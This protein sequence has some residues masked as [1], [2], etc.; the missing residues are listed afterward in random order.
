M[1]IRLIQPKIILNM[2]RKTSSQRNF[3]VNFGPRHKFLLNWVNSVSKNKCLSLVELPEKIRTGVFALELLERLG[4]PFDKKTSK[5][6]PRS[7]DDCLSNL[8]TFLKALEQKGFCYD[9]D[10]QM[11]LYQGKSQISWEIIEYIFSSIYLPSVFDSSEELFSWY[12]FQTQCEVTYPD[13]LVLFKDGS[14]LLKSLA[15]LFPL[16][17]YHDFPETKEEII[18]NLGLLFK[19]LSALQ[20][21]ALFTSEDFFLNE[22]ADCLYVQLWLVFKHFDLKANKTITKSTETSSKSSNLESSFIDSKSGLDQVEKKIMHEERK[23]MYISD[24][25]SKT[26]SKSLNSVPSVREIPHSYSQPVLSSNEV[27][28]CF[29]LTPRI[30]KAWIEGKMKKVLISFVPNAEKFS[31]KQEFYVMELKDALIM[32]LVFVCEA[33]EIEKFE[34]KDLEIW[35]WVRKKVLRLAFGDREECLKYLTGFELMGKRFGLSCKSIVNI[36]KF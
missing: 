25:R 13:L 31:L 36:R 18:S 10:C 12:S 6:P 14:L 4:I 29:L 19:S 8:R 26:Q 20:I 5:L 23:L 30:V 34:L 1:K 32:S 28:I 27:I 33:E 2:I 11:C 35:I 21:P 24:L 9:K 22:Q 17:P 3:F 15:S 7:R 16:P